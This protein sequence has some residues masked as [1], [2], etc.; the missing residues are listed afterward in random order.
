MNTILRD[1]TAEIVKDIDKKIEQE[2]I[3]IDSKPDIPKLE[4]II[5]H[6]DMNWEISNLIKM[7]GKHRHRTK[8]AFGKS[9][10]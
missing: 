8:G 4:M 7:R 2:V 9:H 5:K 6:Y 1:N 10:H 3:L